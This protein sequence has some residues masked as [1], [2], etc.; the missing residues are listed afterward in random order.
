M[1]DE[2]I[3]E[4]HATPLDGA[5]RLHGEYAPPEGGGEPYAM[6]ERVSGEV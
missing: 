2:M 1:P 3:E 5:E 4:L 6:R